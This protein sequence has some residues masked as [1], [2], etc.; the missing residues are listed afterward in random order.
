LYVEALLGKG[1]AL[2]KARRY[3]EAAVVLNK[4]VAEYPKERT[5]GI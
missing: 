1:Q 4:L 5:R 3:E 2:N